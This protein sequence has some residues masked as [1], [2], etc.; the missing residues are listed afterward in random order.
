M[1]GLGPILAHLA[2]QPGLIESLSL[3]GLVKFIIH[4]SA[5]KNDIILTQPSR[6]DP[7]QVPEYL[8][9]T[10]TE[11]LASVADITVEQVAQCW[12]VLRGIA[13]DPDEVKSWRVVIAHVLLA[14]RPLYPPTHFCTTAGCLRNIN[15]VPL[16]K[17]ESRQVALFTLAN[18]AVPAW[19]VHLYCEGCRTNYHN[20][21]SVRDGERTYHAGIP[22]Y[23]QAGD[24][25]FIELGVIN[26]W[27]NLMLTAWTSAT[28]CA[29]FYNS[30]LARRHEQPDDWPFKME[31]ETKQVWDAF[32]I[33]SLLEDCHKRNEV[34]RVPHTG[35][36]KDRFTEAVRA[37][38]GRIRTFGFPNVLHTRQR[39]Y[40]MTLG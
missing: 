5:L 32:T 3:P 36:Q 23:V 22:Q 13:W 25:Q 26:M 21:Y 12:A 38:N 15:H 4:A 37:R 29:N 39:L 1:P 18:G 20:N 28:N 17:S 31:L 40:P 27:I 19:S 9:A 10:I 16:K 6:H 7:E 34:L 33:V 8:S 24:H 35:L 14:S 30:T 11:Y 2:D